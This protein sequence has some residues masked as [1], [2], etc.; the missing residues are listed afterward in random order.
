ML[1]KELGLSQGKISRFFAGF[2]GIKLTRGGSCQIMLRAAER[3][4]DNYR[5]IVRRVQSSA[6][7]VP[8]AA[9]LRIIDSR[10]SS[11]RK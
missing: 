3:C 10:P 11:A 2:F 6:W 4:E 8:S 9:R 7:I 1:N 5:A